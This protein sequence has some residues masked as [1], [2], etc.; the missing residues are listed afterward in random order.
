[1]IHPYAVA[2]FLLAILPL[3]AAPGAS[4][5]LLVGQVTTGGR[6]RAAPV[7]LGTVTGL[8]VHATLAMA[9]LSA[10]VMHS[11]QAFTTVKLAGAAYLIGLGIWTWRSTTP[12]RA[13]RQRSGSPYV[14]ALL[15]NVLN[16]KAASIYLTLVPQFVAPESPLTGQILTLATAHALLMVVWLLTW[17]FLIHR[18]AHVL[19]RPWFRQ[20]IAKAASVVLVILGLRTA[21][22]LG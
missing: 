4:L 17:A 8:Y 13:R 6:R 21:A 10:L 1:M 20:A 5:T 2:G 9:G 7:I 18:A 15:S 12:T 16:P 14:Q 22:T 19:R 11:S 3:I